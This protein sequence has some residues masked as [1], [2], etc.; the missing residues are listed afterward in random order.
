VEFRHVH[1]F[2][3]VVDEHGFANAAH[4][5]YCS[6][7]TVSGH[8][9]DLE[10]ELGTPLFAR[11]R[12]PVELTQAGEAFLVHARRLLRE[13]EAAQ[14][15]VSAIVGLTQGS[16]RLG[17]YPSATAGFVPAVVRAFSSAYPGIRVSLVEAGGA[18]LPEMALENE[19]DLFL[20]Q[21]LPPLEEAAFD[22]AGLWVE[23]F[24]VVAHPDHPIAQH[25]APVSSDE[26][27]EH[28]LVTTGR[29]HS[30]SLMAHRFWADLPRRPAFAFQVG[31]PQS[32]IAL[33][34]ANMGVGVTTEL[35]LRVS[36]TDGLVVRRLASPLA[37]REVAVYT[38]RKRVLSPAAGALAEFIRDPA[39]RPPGCRA[40]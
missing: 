8:I 14:H 25:R 23:D 32:L 26:L 28:P 37:V 36:R 21:T 3:A 12:R 19:V 2:V 15:T 18:Q 1:T 9:A 7:P 13:I 29:F 20:R 34:A 38:P 11:D 40:P 31:Q 27:L 24:M 22:H 33:V 30:D 39:H 5:L 6:Q 10:R 35:A 16:V 17:T 4:A